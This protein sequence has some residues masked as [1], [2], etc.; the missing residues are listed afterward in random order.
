MPRSYQKELMD[1][2]TLATP[3]LKQNLDELHFIN[4]YLGGY[5]IVGDGLRRV[6]LDKN[7]E[8]KSPIHI[9]DVGAGGGHT[10]RYIAD[11]CRKKN[12]SAQLTGLDANDFMRQY[13]Q[14]IINS[15]ANISWETQDAFC[16]DF[17]KYDIVVMSLFC[18]H[19]TDEQL[20]SLFSQ[21]RKGIEKG[22]D[23]TLIIND[24]HRNSIAYWSIWLLTRLFNGSYLV[25]ND[26]PLSVWRAFTYSELKGLLQKAG[27]EHI[28]IRW[29]WAFRWQ[30][31][32]R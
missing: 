25:K 14:N 31:I 22:G 26:A 29:K 27:F 1:D 32:A 28:E 11:W 10:L 4:Q 12:I 30:V 24:L 5:G 17:S 6:I 8:K 16:T 23:K 2:L 3:A 7:F 19:F 9:A 15:Y 21:V 18:H 13:A 20:V